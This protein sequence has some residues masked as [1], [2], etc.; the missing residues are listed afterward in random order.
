MHGS[1][2]RI[3]LCAVVAACLTGAAQAA[4][5]RIISLMP[6][7][8]EI[9]FDLG[10][11]DSVVGVTSYC[12]YPEAAKQKEKVG[13]F[14][15][16]NFEKIVSL[17]PD[18]VV[19][20]LWKSTHIVPRLRKSGVKV[21]EIDLPAN[22]NDIYKSINQIAEAVDKVKEGQALVADLKTRVDKITK[23]MSKLSP[24]PSIYVEID[25]PN[26][27]IS[28][29]SFITDAVERCGTRN[30]FKDLPASGVQ[31]SWESIVHKNP[32]LILVFGARKKEVAARPGWHKISAV[33]N[34]TVIDDIG[35]N[36]LNRPTPRIVVGM[37]RLAERIRL[38]GFK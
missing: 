12:D 31:V 26:W 17:K 30:I 9:L 38:L 3:I 13:D 1:V 22:L 11:G 34:N 25:P 14:I 7:N 4:P 6:S 15:H 27:T 16:P 36:M 19:A 28:G 23:E 32:D 18:L 8:T 35:Q 24:R 2:R 37:E 21:I 5:K 20:G 10:A 29:L 33:K